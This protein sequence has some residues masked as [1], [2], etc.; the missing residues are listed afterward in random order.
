MQMDQGHVKLSKAQNLQ[1]FFREELQQVFEQRKVDVG[2]DTLWYLTQL[3]Y[4]FRRSEQLFDY[5]ADGGTLTPLAEYYRQAHEAESSHERRLYLQRLGDVSL[6]ISSLYSG[7][8]KRKPVNVGYYMSMGETAY[9]FLADTTGSSSRDRA[10]VDIFSD[11]SAR[12]SQLVAALANIAGRGQRS[13]NLLELVCE[14]EKTQCPAL[15]QELE[16]RGVVLAIASPAH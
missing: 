9:G 8:L 1:D 3:L 12:F 6:F 14:W 16:A 2:E 4:N 10:L 5:N 13:G 15:G 7:A 11:L